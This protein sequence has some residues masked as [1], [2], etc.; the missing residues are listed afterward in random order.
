MRVTPPARVRFVG[1]LIAAVCGCRGPR[2]VRMYPG[3][4]RDASQ[5]ARV[6]E[7]PRSIVTRIDSTKTPGRDAFGRYS[8]YELLPGSHRIT[9]V[10]PRDAEHW[11]ATFDH[12]LLAGRS[13]GFR[14][15]QIL[16]DDRAIQSWSPSL[17]DYETAPDLAAPR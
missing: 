2:V 10:Q 3:K 15:T 7:T 14:V 16:R 8:V 12:D 1:I 4:S 9:V 6:Y 17:V 11:S 13:Y 5:I